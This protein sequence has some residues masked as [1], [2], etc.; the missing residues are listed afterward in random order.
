MKST[1]FWIAATLAIAASAAQADA[2]FHHPATGGAAAAASTQAA[3]ARP[4]IVGHPSSPRWK[5]VHANFDHPALAM[6]TLPVIDVNT[7]LV[8]PPVAVHWTLGPAPATLVATAP[9]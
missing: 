3:Q 8:Q 6:R 2:V 9:R 5:L 7:F 4:I 1:S